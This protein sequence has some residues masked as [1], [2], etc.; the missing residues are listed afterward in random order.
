MPIF[1]LMRNLPGVE[2]VVLKGAPLNVL[3]ALEAMGTPPNTP[4][5]TGISPARAESGSS[6]VASKKERRIL[7][8]RIHLKHRV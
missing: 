5:T 6:P 8:L 1:S 3:L 2:A 4:S 7:E